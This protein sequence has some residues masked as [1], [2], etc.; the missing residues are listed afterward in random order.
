[1]SGGRDATEKP[2]AKRLREARRDGKI[3]RTPELGAWVGVM[4]ASWLVPMVL[5]KLMDTAN[6]LLHQVA[7]FIADP[8]PVAAIAMLRNAFQDGALA[9]APLV[10]GIMVGSIAAAAVQGGIRP[11]PKLLKP[12]FSRLNPW[13]GLK[14]MFG[15][16]S[17]WEAAKTL[18]K[19][20]VLALV[21][22]MAVRNLIPT[23]M[24]SGS[25]SL[26]SLTDLA[27]SKALSLLRL[28]A[29]AGLVM[30]AA[31]FAVTKRRLGKELKMTR[32]EVRD[33]HRS[34]E[35][36][37]HVRSAIRSRQIAMSRSRMMSEV[38]KAD[39]VMTNPTHVAVALRYDPAKGAPRVVAKGAGVIAA[40]IRE[41]AADNRIPIVQDVPLARAL[42]K[43]CDI[44]QEIPAEL[45]APVAHVLAF[46]YR[47]KRRGSAAGT[48]RI[49]RAGAGAVPVGASG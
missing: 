23:V 1:M 15:V 43:A 38:A 48:H 42:Y 44:G 40:K 16:R 46:L 47:L 9:L 30:A 13:H 8:Q 21:L 2:T 6:G 33:E 49:S 34:T 41:L 32:Q 36:D 20:G 22:Y 29:V 4:L 25:L 37:P 12:K 17:L 18:L 5:G 26:S 27:D 39:V 3:A 35:G 24:A 10:G 45:Y 28:A 14:R 19:T 7:V 31:D 11:A